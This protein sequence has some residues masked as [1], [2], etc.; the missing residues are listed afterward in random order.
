M[1]TREHEEG[2][3]LKVALEKAL[4]DVNGREAILDLLFAIEKL[5]VTEALVNETKLGKTVKSVTTK[6][7]KADEIA[8]KAQSILKEWT[9]IAK[10]ESKTKSAQKGSGKSG[11]AGA[12]A[13][14]VK[15]AAAIDVSREVEALSETRLKIFQLFVDTLSGGDKTQAKA[16]EETAFLVEKALD[17]AFPSLGKEYV[18]RARTLVINMKK[19]EPLR[20]AVASRALTPEELVIKPVSELGN[21]EFLRRREAMRLEEFESKRLDW[22]KANA[23]EIA[24]SLGCNPNND[25]VYEQEAA[26]DDGFD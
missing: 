23:E 2:L 3:R 11:A 21:E 19:N 9:R 14:P 18:P 22:E 16:V 6:F 20:R 25:W 1:A 15:A 26:S 7:G 13:G 5:K 10:E 4:E 8:K 24:L 17:T 12:G